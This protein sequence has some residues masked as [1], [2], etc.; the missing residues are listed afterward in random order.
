[1]NVV[2]FQKHT[3]SSGIFARDKIH[4]LECTNRTEGDIFK[5]SDG[6]GDEIEH[7]RGIKRV[8]VIPAKA[9]IFLFQD[10]VNV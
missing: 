8:I 6:C 4:F 3:G 9:G 5:V 2:M 10:L 1:V 7:E